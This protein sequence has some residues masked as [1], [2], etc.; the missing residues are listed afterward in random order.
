MGASARRDLG[1]DGLGLGAKPLEDP[2][3]ERQPGRCLPVSGAGGRRVER[4][5]C[6]DEVLPGVTDRLFGSGEGHPG[7]HEAVVLSVVAISM[8]VGG[9]AAGC[10][11]GTARTRWS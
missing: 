4:V 8:R 3:R 1:P 2:A 5:A 10:W 9:S 11:S 7:S 6:L